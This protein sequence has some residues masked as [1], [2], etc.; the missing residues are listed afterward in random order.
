MLVRTNNNARVGNSV[1]IARDGSILAVTNAGRVKVYRIDDDLRQ[2]T[3]LEIKNGSQDEWFGWS[4]DI[5]STG[6][7]IVIS[8]GSRRTNDKVQVF[9]NRFW[10]GTLSIYRKI[11]QSI[12]GYANGDL[13]GYHPQSTAISGKG[14]VIVNSGLRR[15]R[16]CKD[17]HTFR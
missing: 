11:G 17:F 5:S 9:S 2:I 3:L 7:D 16:L 13:L 8:S 15:N 14:T 12:Y 6:S 1:G 4:L 10:N